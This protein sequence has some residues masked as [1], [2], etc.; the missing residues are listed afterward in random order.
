MWK[1][2]EQRNQRTESRA[3]ADLMDAEPEGVARHQGEVAD[4]MR[5]ESNTHAQR[6]LKGAGSLWQEGALCDVILEAEGVQF[7]GHKAI[8]A[9]V[10]SYCRLLFTGRPSPFPSGGLVKLQGV[11]AHGLE[12]VLGFVY[13]GHM[14]LSLN[15]VEETLQAAK[16]LM[17]RDA[18]KICLHFLD[19]SLTPETCTQI[20]S[21][22]HRLGP[23]QFH[24]RVLGYLGAH[25]KS[26]LKDPETLLDLDPKALLELVSQDDLGDIS[27]TNVLR[28]TLR[29]LQH[30]PDHAVHAHAV[31]CKLRLPLVPPEALLDE[32]G[33]R[34]LVCADPHC[35]QLLRQALAYHARPYL[36]P[37]LQGPSTTVRGATPCLVVLG[38]RTAGNLVSREVWATA[39]GDMDWS[40]LGELG[41]PLYNHCCVVLNNFL[42]VLGGQ[43]QFDPCGKQPTN[44]ASLLL[45]W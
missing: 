37:A 10:S 38:G 6:L 17:I 3:E 13:R 2:M 19:V 34:P 20:L 7:A 35:L 27:E 21:V 44:E 41:A 30:N 14:T 4:G 24:R 40:R 9:S 43:H 15:V 32:L 36:Q 31:F 39:E 8:L 18:I 25:C 5:L 26:L 23:S 29:W 1:K 33:E 16:I 22:A 42:F 11:R 12:Q 45:S 28:G